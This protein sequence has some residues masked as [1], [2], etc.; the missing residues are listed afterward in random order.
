MLA[1]LSNVEHG[2]G[3][4]HGHGPRL[5]RLS[6]GE[7][8]AL[9]QR[10]QAAELRAGAAEDRRVEAEREL[11]AVRL[12]AEHEGRE[13]AQ[14][15]TQRELAQ[16]AADLGAVRAAEQEAQ[17]RAAQLVEVQAE[18]NWLQHQLGMQKQCFE[19]ELE[20]A[21]LGA[22]LRQVADCL[23]PTFAEVEHGAPAPH[24]RPH[25]EASSSRSTGTAGSRLISG[26]S[27]S[28]APEAVLSGGYSTPGIPHGS[29]LPQITTVLEEQQTQQ[30]ALQARLAEAERRILK[31]DR[32]EVAVQELTSQIASYHEDIR[33]NQQ[34][35]QQLQ[36][37][38]AQALEAPPSLGGNAP[39]EASSPSRPSRS[40]ERM[41]S[42]PWSQ[43]ASSPAPSCKLRMRP[44]SSPLEES[45]G[46]I[47]EQADAAAPEQETE[48]AAGLRRTVWQLQQR[49]ANEQQKTAS[50]EDALNA[51]LVRS[52]T[53]E[54]DNTELRE[55]VG[56][57]VGRIASLESQLCVQVRS[58][59][60]QSGVS[61][62]ASSGGSASTGNLAATA[63]GAGLPQQ[64]RRGRGA[65]DRM[66]PGSPRSAGSHLHR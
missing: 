66:R 21:R 41:T 51:T 17:Q 60:S 10:L 30:Q 22:N 8:Q 43:S 53:M 18:R 36:H 3:H 50:L 46:A 35:L 59:R 23:S 4:G 13:A 14:D 55:F 33:L 61:R 52:A 54:A 27:S 65:A 44:G 9:Q 24:G 12:T 48:E 5:K 64:R 39:G 34:L 32:V 1:D 37:Q 58:P 16:A 26:T 29:N 47:P 40:V 45:A 42:M 11:R 19:S 49:I 2:H 25:E 31:A 15:A 6:P 38:H 28:E 7:V 63:R 20:D 62:Q 56:S 57:L